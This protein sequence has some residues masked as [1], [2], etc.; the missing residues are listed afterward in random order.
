MNLNRTS[1]E[2]NQ[3][4][5]KGKG[6]ESSR[7]EV[8]SITANLGTGVAA[9]RKRHRF[10]KRSSENRQKKDHLEAAYRTKPP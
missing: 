7:V 6:M 3:E 8:T 5:R 1:N 4:Q 2:G 9:G 10:G